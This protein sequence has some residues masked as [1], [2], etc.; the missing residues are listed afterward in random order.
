MS[1]S[2]FSEKSKFSG[3]TG[4]V[5]NIPGKFVYFGDESAED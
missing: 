4:V 2:T 1:Y 5:D 3:K